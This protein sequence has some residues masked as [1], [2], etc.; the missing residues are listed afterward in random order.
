[1]RSQCIL[2]RPA[3]CRYDLFFGKVPENLPRITTFTIKTAMEK[4]P[5]PKWECFLHRGN[6]DVTISIFQTL[7]E[8]GSKFP[9]AVTDLIGSV[10][11]V[12]KFDRSKTE[13][14]T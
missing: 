5:F 6:I 3:A 8:L 11:R 2:D 12:K 1:M 14:T 9:K 7:K 10:D 4:F 13:I